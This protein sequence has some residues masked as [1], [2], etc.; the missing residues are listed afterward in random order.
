MNDYVGVPPQRSGFG[1]GRRGMP[2]TPQ[3][4]PDSFTLSTAAQDFIQQERIRRQ[5]ELAA[6]EAMAAQAPAPAVPMVNDIDYAIGG[7]DAQYLEIELDPGEA[8]IAENGAMIWKDRVVRFDTVLGDGAKSG[9]INKVISAGTNLLGGEN[10]FLGE[11]RHAG[12][13]GKA[14]VA[15]GGRSPGHILPIRLEAMGGKLV[16]QRGAFLAAA[17]GISVSVRLVEDLWAGLEGGEGFILQELSGTGWAFLHVGGSL[18][19]R[20]LG[21]GEQLHVDAGCIAAFEPGVQFDTDD[22]GTGFVSDIKNTLTGG[23][24]WLFARLTGPGKVW[25]QSLPFRRLSRTVVKEAGL[26]NEATTLGGRDGGP[27]GLGDIVDGVDM[28]SKLFKS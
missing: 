18:I 21:V 22:V 5:A 14:R 6:A 28:V 12:A 20:E 23:E 8:V 10:L 19:E 26:R 1:F 17:K 11:F 3:P 25:I 7:S 16:C 15:L 2:S 9:I 4:A 24:G 13:S 27:L